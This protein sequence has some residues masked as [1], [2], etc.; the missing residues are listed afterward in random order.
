M[1]S[2]ICYNSVACEVENEIFSLTTSGAENAG[3]QMKLRNSS[4]NTIIFD[5]ATN[6][7]N[8]VTYIN[9]VS[10]ETKKRR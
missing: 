2:L 4:E 5:I 6:F 7:M 9:Y 3:E 1:Y 8:C 10:H